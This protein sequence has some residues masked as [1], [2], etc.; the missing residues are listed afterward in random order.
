[1]EWKRCKFDKIL[2]WRKAEDVEPVRE[3][4]RAAEIWRG[5]YVLL[6]MRSALLVWLPC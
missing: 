5:M 4:K 2:G 6:G 3:P 1:M